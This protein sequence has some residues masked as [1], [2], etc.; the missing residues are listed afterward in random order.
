MVA[1]E[2]ICRRA[3]PW[4]RLISRRTTRRRSKITTGSASFEGSSARKTVPEALLNSEI[5]SATWLLVG[6]LFLAA[7]T[8]LCG[9]S[10]VV[11]AVAGADRAGGPFTTLV[12]SEAAFGGRLE[13]EVAIGD[14]SSI[15]ASVS[16]CFVEREDREDA[17]AF[18]AVRPPPFS[19]LYR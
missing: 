8:M 19:T 1:R 10:K 17:G 12:R 18:A 7:M 6:C 4:S 11:L 13:S 15:T 2:S 5:P 14:R 9:T 16:C 3:H